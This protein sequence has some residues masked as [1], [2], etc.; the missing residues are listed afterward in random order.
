MV[1]EEIEEITTC[2]YKSL[3]TAQD[4]TDPNEVIHFVP[5]K[6]TDSMNNMLETPFS[7]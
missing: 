2:F 1:L 6:V 3:F 7:K 4:H 5:R